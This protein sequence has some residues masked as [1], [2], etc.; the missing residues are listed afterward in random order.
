MLLRTIAR[1]VVVS[2]CRS[3]LPRAF[4]STTS[5]RVERLVSAATART[6][7]EG[8]PVKFVDV[9]APE[10][11]TKA[12]IPDAVNVHAI[13]TYLATSDADGIQKLTS[14]FEGLFQ[15]AGINTE[16]HVITYEEC[17]KTL[18]GASCR[19]LYLFKL[20]GHSSVSVLD[21]G[22]EGWIKQGYPLSEAPP[23]VP[24]RGTFQAS[25]APSGLWSGRDDVLKAIADESDTVLLDVRDMEEWRGS[26]SSPYGVDFAPRKG[27]LP[28]AVSIPWYNFMRTTD[29]GLTRFKDPEEIRELCAASGVVPDKKVIVYCFKGAR[30]ANTFTALKEAG[31]D[32][33]TNY[34]ASWNEWSR[35][36]NLPTD[37]EEY[38]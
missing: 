25:W 11:Y 24:R 18:Y 13:F 9:R 35:D 19:G 14:T 20:L 5:W 12:R 6:L 2:R 21:G 36:P 10:E 32:H 27:R 1:R 8:G 37:A 4:S 23:N 7:A 31:F 33:V 15:D 38:Y 28:D 26:S 29:D 34:F 3:V 30:A 17:L 16:D 22:L